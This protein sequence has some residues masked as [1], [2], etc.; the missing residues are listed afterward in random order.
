M[1]WSFSSQPPPLAL[2]VR[3]KEFLEPGISPVCYMSP[4]SSDMPKRPHLGVHTN[5]MYQ[6]AGSFWCGWA[7]APIRHLYYCK[8]DTS[9]PVCPTFN[10]NWRYLCFSIWDSSTS[11]TGKWQATFSQLRTMASDLEAL[12]LISGI[13]LSAAAHLEIWWREDPPNL[14]HLA[15]WL[16]P[17]KSLAAISLILIYTLICQINI[18]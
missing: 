15:P 12:I 8:H 17:E 7:A 11:L 10:K 16:H 2:L 6:L 14:T 9:K 3:Q 13:Q 5:K 18:W 4:P 1:A